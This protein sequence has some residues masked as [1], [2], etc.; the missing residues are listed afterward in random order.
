MLSPGFSIKY[1]AELEPLMCSCV[2]VLC[3]KLDMACSVADETGEAHV[4]I[5]E[6]LLRTAIVRTLLILFMLAGCL[7]CDRK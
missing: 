6:M 5:F 2:N 4:N 7:S 1:L 3:G